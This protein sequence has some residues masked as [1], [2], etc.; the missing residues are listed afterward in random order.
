MEN[1][2]DNA[3]K[4]LRRVPSAT[5]VQVADEAIR[6]RYTGLW[7]TLARYLFITLHG[8]TS[9][10]SSTYGSH[11]NPTRN[12]CNSMILD[13]PS[14]YL[15][16]L[17]PPG[18]LP[19]SGTKNKIPTRSSL[20]VTIQ[21]S[22]TCIIPN[23]CVLSA[24]SHVQISQAHPTRIL[25]DSTSIVGTRALVEVLGEIQQKLW[26]EFSCNAAGK[27]VV[28]EGVCFAAVRVS[29]EEQHA[30]FIP[31]R[32]TMID[33]LDSMVAGARPSNLELP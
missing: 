7:G 31:T 32:G 30:H 6:M 13:C 11:L 22:Y 26:W 5:S 24:T 23:Q 27:V 33:D 18:C 28:D 25:H 1:D 12:L 16:L 15:N 19:T 17:D 29:L 9:H 8:P 14:T 3:E 4:R 2:A 20:I 21:E 10:V